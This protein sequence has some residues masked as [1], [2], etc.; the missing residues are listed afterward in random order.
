MLAIA[1]EFLIGDTQE[2]NEIIKTVVVVVVVT[3]F[4][5]C[6]DRNETTETPIYFSRAEILKGK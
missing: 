4:L 2:R 5:Y 3:E 6:S 1:K